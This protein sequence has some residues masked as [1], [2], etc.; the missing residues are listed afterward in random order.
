MRAKVEV[1]GDVAEV[2]RGDVEIIDMDHL[3]EEKGYSSERR[4]KELK[5]ALLKY[6]NVVTVNGGCAHVEKGDVEIVDHDN[7]EDDV[8][9]LKENNHSAKQPEPKKHRSRCRR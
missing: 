4:E 3:K 8:D 9:D 5:N 2:T 1:Y 7:D 6:Q